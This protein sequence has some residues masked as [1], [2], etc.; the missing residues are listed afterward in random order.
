MLRGTFL[1]AMVA[2][3]LTGAL[4]APLGICL[5]PAQKSAHSC[6]AGE[7]KPQ[8][9]IRAN[10]CTVRT[11]L[12]ALVVTPKLPAPAPSMVVPQFALF[13]EFASANGL[14]ATAAI[15][16]GSPPPDASILRI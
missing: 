8:G 4:L 7:S 11:P 6:C 2:T 10:C 3:L 13:N 1:R 15:P 5:Q 12:P 16:R 9:T 14:T